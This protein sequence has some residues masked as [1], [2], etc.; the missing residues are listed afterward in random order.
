MGLG[1]DQVR[2]SSPVT[3]ARRGSLLGS[4]ARWCVWFSGAEP[5][6]LSLT[7]GRSAFGFGRWVQTVYRTGGRRTQLGR[8]FFPLV[9]MRFS[10]S[11]A[12]ACVRARDGDVAACSSWLTTERVY[13]WDD[14]FP[15][16]NL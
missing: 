1:W 14:Q 7:A 8:R 15:H 9:G 10:Q 16:S 13:G 2:W 5:R 6:S 12:A 4:W 11:A 3:G